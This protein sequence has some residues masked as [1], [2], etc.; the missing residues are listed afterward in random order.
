[1]MAFNG[2]L[3]WILA[4]WMDSISGFL[5]NQIFIPSAPFFNFVLRWVYA[6][7]F[8]Q[9]TK[10]HIF[11][12]F[13]IN[14]FFWKF[15][16]CYTFHNSLVKSPPHLLKFFLNDAFYTSSLYSILALYGIQICLPPVGRDRCGS[17]QSSSSRCAGDTFCQ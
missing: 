9:N 14:L 16:S 3:N 10:W 1:M 11:K 6:I 4:W 15:W 5:V 12:G 8:R 2:H 7:A 17:S 13:E